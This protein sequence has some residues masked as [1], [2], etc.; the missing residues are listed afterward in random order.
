LRLVR[1]LSEAQPGLITG[2]DDDI[3]NACFANK[4]RI[5]ILTEIMAI[6]SRL[7]MTVERANFFAQ[8][9]GFLPL[10][11][12]FLK[13][14]SVPQQFRVESIVFLSSVLLL[15]EQVPQVDL[16]KM[17]VDLLA[18]NRSDPDVQAQCLFALSK[19]A[20]IPELRDQV[21]R[22][23]VLDGV[24]ELASSRN[25]A[26]KAMADLILEAGAMLN[27]NIRE[28]LKGPRFD[29]FNREWLETLPGKPAKS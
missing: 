27:P 1:N 19:L 12:G 24:L 4:K 6:A 2:F 26:V 20:Y 16:V 10:I 22:P 8:F 18:A 23:A 3:V 28:S 9:A 14:P 15:C 25:A 13:V 17:I 21:F 11:Y 29:C 7:K 5:E